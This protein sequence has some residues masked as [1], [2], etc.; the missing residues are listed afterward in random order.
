M[1]RDL[2]FTLK[3]TEATAEVGKTRRAN[4]RRASSGKATSLCR[5]REALYHDSPDDAVTALEPGLGE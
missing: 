3:R 1:L 5:G 4:W 2:T